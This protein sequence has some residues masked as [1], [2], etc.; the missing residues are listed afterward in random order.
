MQG[1]SESFVCL[2]L[3]FAPLCETCFDGFNLEIDYLALETLV[4]SKEKA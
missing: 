1:T 2:C 4:L 3:L